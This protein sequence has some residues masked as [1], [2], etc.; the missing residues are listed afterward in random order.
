MEMDLTETILASLHH[1]SVFS[2]LGFLVAEWVVLS[3]TPDAGA[4]RRIAAF[5]LAYGL[6]ALLVVGAG[7]VR[8]V[9]GLKPWAFY[10]GNPIFW[11]KMG[12]GTLVGLLSVWPTVVI[13]RWRKRG[14]VPSLGEFL[15]IRKWVTAELVFFI[16]LP[17]C[18]AAMARGIGY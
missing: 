17:I 6:A 16:G 12:L 18:A 3:G 4:L 5:D 7:I 9:Y 15:S 1:L 13:L 10:S 11:V 2:M 14:T 8:I